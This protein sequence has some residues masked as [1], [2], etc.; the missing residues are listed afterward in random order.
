MRP[1]SLIRSAPK[2]R[3]VSHLESREGSRNCPSLLNVPPL[4]LAYPP[5]YI[6]FCK[7]LRWPVQHRQNVPAARFSSKSIMM[8]LTEE[9][10]AKRRARDQAKRAALKAAN[11]PAPSATTPLPALIRV[12]HSTP[13]LS[14]TPVLRSLSSSLFPHRDGSRGNH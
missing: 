1:T 2:S 14:A 8:E 12:N 3:A 6:V 5:H 10:K 11:N 13:S 7:I 4:P 9:Q